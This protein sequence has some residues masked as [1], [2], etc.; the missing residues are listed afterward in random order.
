MHSAFARC[1][2][3]Q[4]DEKKAWD[5][6][7]QESLLTN[8]FWKQWAGQLR[9]FAN[10]VPPSALGW[11]GSVVRMSTR[12]RHER[13]EAGSGRTSRCRTCTATGARLGTPLHT[14]PVRP[15]FPFYENKR[16]D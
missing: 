11:D 6:A 7:L 15:R 8:P 5:I 14:S 10:A 3:A 9:T 12:S 2:E 1:M 16:L 13:T 4:G